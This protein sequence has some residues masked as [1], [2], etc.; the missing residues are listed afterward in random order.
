MTIEE[1]MLQVA[2]AARS[3]AQTFAVAKA[4]RD[5]VAALDYVVPDWR[6]ETLQ[7]GRDGD[8]VN[9]AWDALIEALEGVR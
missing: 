7:K 9:E 1:Q 4:A 6:G 2:E 5:L 8:E 3:L